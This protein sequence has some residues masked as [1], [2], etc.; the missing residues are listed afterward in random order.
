MNDIGSSV[1]PTTQVSQGFVKEVSNAI[2]VAAVSE[3]QKRAYEMP[4]ALDWLKSKDIEL[5]IDDDV[6]VELS[7]ATFKKID[8]LM[9]KSGG[10]QGIAS[11]ENALAWLRSNTDVL[12]STVSRKLT[13]LCQSRA[14]RILLLNQEKESNEESTQ[15]L[16]QP[17]KV[18]R[19]NG[20]CPF[21]MTV[22][23]TVPTYHN[24]E[25]CLSFENWW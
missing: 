11:M 22:T 24:V 6:S 19:P 3:E 14:S 25:K 18:V 23:G 8:S 1:V 2:N 10:D 20:A 16:C 15:E 7:V 4:G 13:V 5:D 17:D 12:L 9:P 21:G